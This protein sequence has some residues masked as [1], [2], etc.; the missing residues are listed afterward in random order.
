MPGRSILPQSGLITQTLRLMRGD[1]PCS[2]CVLAQAVAILMLLKRC[3]CDMPSGS[4]AGHDQRTPRATL[5]PL[6]TF[7]HAP[8]FPRLLPA[9]LMPCCTVVADLSV[10]SARARAVIYDAFSHASL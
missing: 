6:H 3:C 5:V 10:W 7:R 8:R 4:V 1:P 2:W 9:S